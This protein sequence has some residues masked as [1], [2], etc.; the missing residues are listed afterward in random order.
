MLSI[1]FTFEIFLGCHTELPNVVEQPLS[2]CIDYA[3][4]AELYGY[5]IYKNVDSFSERASVTEQCP[6]AGTWQDDCRQSWVMSHKDK[7]DLNELMNVCGQNADCAFHILDSKPHP[8]LLQQ[9]DLCIQYADRYRHDCVMHA[10][11][12]WYFEWPD[13]EEIARV[14][15]ERSPFP[16]QIGTFIGARV[17]CD[18]V[19]TCDG[20]PENK[21]M[22]EKYVVEYQ[23][24]S[25]CPNQHRRRINRRK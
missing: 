2:L 18:G 16:E 19:G 10:I 11:Q 14:A 17:A 13:A 22:C 24:K 21:W 9:V 6:H 23:D 4:D 1:L 15:K 7:Y 20:T 25:K 8:D 5:C 12:R 3:K